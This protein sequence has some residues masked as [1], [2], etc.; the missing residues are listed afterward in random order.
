MKW[1]SAVA[2]A[3]L[4]SSSAQAADLGGNCCADLE[5]RIAELEATTAR[6]GNR[7][8]SVTVYGQVNAGIMRYDG[9]I[10]GRLFSVDANGKRTNGQWGA[11]ADGSDDKV[12]DNSVSES[13][14]GFRGEANI[15]ESVKAGFVIE[16]GVGEEGLLDL[17]TE[18]SVKV[19]HA[20]WFIESKQL[21]RLTVGKTSTATDDIDTFSVANT[22][23]VVKGLSWEPVSGQL[24]G[25]YA[26]PYDGTKTNV[27]R[28]DSPA[29]AGFVLSAAWADEDSY[30]VALRYAGEFSQFKV[31]AA[32]GYKHTAGVPELL[33]NQDADTFIVS[34]GVQ[35][36]PTGLFV[37]GYY[38]DIDTGLYWK[39]LI[40]PAVSIGSDG[41]HV[42]AGLEPKLWSVGKTTFFAEYADMKA[43]GNWKDGDEYVSVDA[44]VK[45]WGIGIVQAFDSA[46]LDLYVTYRSYS[47]DLSVVGGEKGVG[48]IG[49]EL[50][51]NADVFLAGGRIKF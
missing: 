7:K 14:F 20:A 8:V 51:A 13:R 25:G 45:F 39:G 37:Q 21:G 15:S 35:H 12:I 9:D 41:W 44:G 17:G 24:L 31:A 42:V 18:R 33:A 19:R 3:V 38:G 26:W 5:E 6:K 43:D 30:D 36:V 2:L 27:I 22:G 49:G 40:E 11:V 1:F 32:A 16:L 46:A 50:D 28:Y 23:A 48:A 47:G 10:K 34:A 4:A 29:L